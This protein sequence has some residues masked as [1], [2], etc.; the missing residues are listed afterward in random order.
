MRAAAYWFLMVSAAMLMCSS[1]AALAAE[2]SFASW[3]AQFKHE[4]R[5]QGIPDALLNEAFE[6]VAPIAKVLTLD[7][8][9]PESTLS[10]S[11]YLESTV[12]ESRVTK[13]RALMAQH[14]ALLDR[15]ART[16]GV[17][18]QFIAALWG[19]ETDFGRNTGNFNVVA[20][21]ATLAYDGRRSAF[22]RKELMN[23]L[24]ILR[25]DHIGVEE[26]KG[27]WAGAMGQTQFMPSSFLSFAVDDNADG[28][29]DIWN[30]QADVFASIANYLSQSGWEEGAAC[31]E[32]VTLPPRFDA[33]LADIS[34]EKP[35]SQWSALGVTHAGGAT[36]G[37]E[38]RMAALIFP[39]DPEEGA[40]LIGANYK[41]LL[42]WNRSRYFATAVCILAERLAEDG[43]DEPSLSISR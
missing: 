33:S 1:G 3:L 5:G 8:K 24:T 27:S 6:G 40:Y 7:R 25:D 17:E 38:A 26:M 23:A 35:L 37:K 42:K 28:K 30:T 16:Y 43:Q 2:Q 32:E 21:L 31:A 34:Q 15:I 18:P 10:F 29:P 22:F 11:E 36:L 39:G 14:R 4:A 19:M 13:G 9:Q 12:P 41:T 20:A